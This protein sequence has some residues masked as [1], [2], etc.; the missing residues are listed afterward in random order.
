MNSRV[1]LLVTFSTLIVLIISL[2]MFTDWFSK[3]TGYFTGED[4]K[5]KLAQC[6]T[7]KGSEFYGTTECAECERERKLL[8]SAFKELSY[9]DCQENKCSNLK[10]IP[11]WYINGTFEY[12]FKTLKELHELSGCTDN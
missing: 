7:N 8:G 2:Y 1:K 12:G 6:M 3:V 9:I 11:A 5:I 10:S 4:E